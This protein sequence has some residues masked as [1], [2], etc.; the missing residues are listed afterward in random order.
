MPEFLSAST[1]PARLPTAATSFVKSATLAWPSRR[2]GSARRG[3]AARTAGWPRN[4]GTAS[5]RRFWLI[6]RAALTHPSQS[7]VYAYGIVLWELITREIPFGTATA[8]QVAFAWF[9]SPARSSLLSAMT[10]RGPIFLSHS[11]HCWRT[12]FADAGL[13]IP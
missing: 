1:E 8:E 11:H 5:R 12:L 10:M 2:A 13:G 3:R 7:D 9:L 6:G 4:C